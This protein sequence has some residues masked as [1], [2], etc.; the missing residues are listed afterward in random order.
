MKSIRNNRLKADW[1]V[2]APQRR[3]PGESFRLSAEDPGCIVCPSEDCPRPFP[4]EQLNRGRLNRSR[5]PA[6]S[7]DALRMLLTLINGYQ[8]IHLNG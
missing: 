7:Y 3:N 4:W 5:P 6:A 8:L 2:P 1:D